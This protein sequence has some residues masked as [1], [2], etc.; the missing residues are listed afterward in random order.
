MEKDKYLQE[1]QNLIDTAQK[2][3]YPILK[4]LSEKE[5]HIENEKQKDIYVQDLV[6]IRNYSEEHSIFYN[7]CSARI[8]IKFYAKR[9][10]AFLNKNFESIERDF[11]EIEIDRL[12]EGKCYRYKEGADL[13]TYSHKR[14]IEFL[15][16][17]LDSQDLKSKKIN[18]FTP[19]KAVQSFEIL[20]ILDYL[21]DSR[22]MSYQNQAKFI[23]HLIDKSEANILKEIGNR[24]N[25]QSP[26]TR[27]KAFEKLRKW[28]NESLIQK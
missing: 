10:D 23:S 2:R 27:R 20:G 21:K 11:I 5:F 8:Y 19:F 28:I 16:A 4:H 7:N 3:S 22:G 26:L 9:L 24:R 6:N 1:F 13:F 18:S 14:I 15:E 25:N 17:K 12:L